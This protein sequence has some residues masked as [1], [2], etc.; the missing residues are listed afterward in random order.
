MGLLFEESYDI[1]HLLTG[2]QAE[3]GERI[4]RGKTLTVFDERQE[5]PKAITSLKYFKANASEQTIAAAGSL[6]GLT[7]PPAKKQTSDRVGICYNG[8]CLNLKLG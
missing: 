6:L 7:P 8:G 4:T 5:C 3:T 2:I 1:Q